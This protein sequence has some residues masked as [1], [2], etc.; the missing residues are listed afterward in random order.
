[1]GSCDG[2]FRKKRYFSCK[3][4]YGIFLTAFNLNITFRAQANTMER[5]SVIL[6]SDKSQ[7]GQMFYEDDKVAVYSTGGQRVTGRAKWAYPVSGKDQ[8]KY[9]VIGIETDVRMSY[10]SLLSMYVCHVSN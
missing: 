9:N 10:M 1:M 6:S 4:D 8:Q 3:D 2:T 5:R 7:T